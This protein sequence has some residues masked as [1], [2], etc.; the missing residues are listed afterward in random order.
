MSKSEEAIGQMLIQLDADLSARIA[1]LAPESRRIAA[2]SLKRAYVNKAQQQQHQSPP[3]RLPTDLITQF[4]DADTEKLKRLIE[5][6]KL[7]PLQHTQHQQSTHDPFSQLPDAAL[8]V[9]LQFLTSWGNTALLCAA[10]LAPLPNSVSSSSCSHDPL[11]PL[12][13]IERKPRR[14]PRQPSDAARTPISFLQLDIFSWHVGRYLEGRI[15]SYSGSVNREFVW[16][17]V[18]EQHRQTSDTATATATAFRLGVP[19]SFDNTMSDLFFDNPQRLVGSTVRVLDPYLAYPHIIVDSTADIKFVSFAGATLA[20]QL[21]D[22][23]AVGDAHLRNE[24]FSEALRAY[25]DALC[26]GNSNGTPPCSEAVIAKDLFNNLAQ[27]LLTMGENAAEKGGASFDRCALLAAAFALLMEPENPKANLRYQTALEQI[28][29]VASQQ[30]KG[31][32][33]SDSLLLSFDGKMPNL[34]RA[35]EALK[36]DPEDEMQQQQQ[37][38]SRTPQEWKQRGNDLSASSPAKAAACYLAGL[39]HDSLRLLGNIASN[40]ARCAYCLHNHH[41]VLVLAP[42]AAFF[43]T[44]ASA[45]PPSLIAEK[46]KM[47]YTLSLLQLGF[48]HDVADTVAKT[49]DRKSM[50]ELD[51]AFHSKL[52]QV[53]DEM[54][55]A[56]DLPAIANGELLPLSEYVHS[57]ISVRPVPGKGRGLVLSKAAAASVK[58][59]DLLMAARALAV[60]EHPVDDGGEGAT[61]TLLSLQY[62]GEP[63]QPDDAA[64]LA[65]VTRKAASVPGCTALLH[66]LNA[67]CTDDDGASPNSNSAAEC[68]DLKRYRS[69]WRQKQRVFLLEP[70][71]EVGFD[72]GRIIEAV[73]SN[74]FRMDDGRAAVFFLASLINHDDAY[75]VVRQQ[76]G[77]FWFFFAARSIDAGEELTICY[78][79]P[80]DA[81]FQ[82]RERN[83]G[84][85]WMIPTPAPAPSARILDIYAELTGGGTMNQ[86]QQQQQHHQRLNERELLSR[87]EFVMAQRDGTEIHVVGKNDLLE[88][89]VL[90]LI[91]NKA[92]KAAILKMPAFAQWL[93]YR[94]KNRLI[95][96]NPPLLQWANEVVM[97]PTAA[98]RKSEVFTRLVAAVRF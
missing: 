84:A 86:Q 57:A 1:R 13:A 10:P 80:A 96:S 74:S 73:K 38:A 76:F 97:D 29:R 67:L 36:L 20:P 71:P 15:R 69:S 95:I 66:D 28:Q 41:P 24:R 25:R 46:N 17:H 9:L 52:R 27:M 98:D 39:R 4:V 40:T 91:E 75:N 18:E 2:V 3:Q 61:Q 63:L 26:G 58:R 60:S 83:L 78:Y 64:I 93:A 85:K 70:Y 51:P 53:A 8:V 92:A 42:L 44:E 6:N 35:V 43:S 62:D 77:D 50:L 88:K 59:G 90:A 81:Y 7:I 19:A 47:L 54:R 65:A 31:V 22:A 32:D 72:R 56:F 37:S 14:P 23:K 12:S 48:G 94:E 68:I 79:E 49:I 30:N 34:N 89:I 55:G 82:Q 33:N 16:L 21:A 5:I 45:A 11:I 87:F